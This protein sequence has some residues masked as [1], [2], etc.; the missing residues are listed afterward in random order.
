VRWTR[1]KGDVVAEICTGGQGGKALGSVLSLVLPPFFFGLWGGAESG[2]IGWLTC[3]LAGWL[4]G[5][6]LVGG[7][8]GVIGG[9]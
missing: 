1:G 2:R 4:T 9:N 6:R 8:E 7:L 3:W 5:T